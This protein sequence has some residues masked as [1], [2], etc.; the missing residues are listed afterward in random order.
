M[1]IYKIYIF[2]IFI[3]TD[4]TPV[5]DFGFALHSYPGSFILAIIFSMSHHIPNNYF[6]NILLLY[7][8]PIT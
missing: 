8:K 2:Y 3:L 5:L 7:L 6:F 4:N 1:Y